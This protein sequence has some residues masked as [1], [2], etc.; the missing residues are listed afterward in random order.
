MLTYADVCW[1]SSSTRD[2]YADASHNP[3][4]LN[5][6]KA[7]SKAGPGG[8]GGGG[9]AGTGGDKWWERLACS[10][11]RGYREAMKLAAAAEEEAMKPAAA[12][13]EEALTLAA[14]AEEEEEGEEEEEHP[15][16]LAERESERKEKKAE[17]WRAGDA[18]YRGIEV[19]RFS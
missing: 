12:A 1:R 4:L 15:A 7:Q 17:A 14:A 16:A 5:V 3:D 2:L 11:P 9:G 19:Q 18:T 8:R 6:I 13:E 10:T